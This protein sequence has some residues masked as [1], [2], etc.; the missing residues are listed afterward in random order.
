[1]FCR[2]KREPT[3]GL[4]PPT[5]PHY[6]FPTLHPSPS[7]W[8]GNCASLGGF[9]YSWRESLS[10]AYR[11]VSAGCN[12]VALHAWSSIGARDEASGVGRGMT[13]VGVGCEG[14]FEGR[15][16]HLHLLPLTALEG[17]VVMLDLLT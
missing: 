15:E 12:T 2:Q 4:E 11:R 3:S 5:Y 16:A 14:V 6:E 17:P 13:E 1:M 9:R 7:W 10:A 8:S